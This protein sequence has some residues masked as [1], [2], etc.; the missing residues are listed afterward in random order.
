MSVL[1]AL[2][3]ASCLVASGP[4]EGPVRAALLAAALICVQLRL[5]CNLL[6]GMVAVEH[7]RGGPTGPIWNEL[8]DRIA[9]PLFLVAAG[10][11]AAGAGVVWGAPVG[12]LAGLLAVLTAYVRELGRA[13]GCPAD[14]SGPMAKPHRMAVLTAACAISIAEPLWRWRGQSLAIAL[15]I[16]ALGSALTVVLRTLRLARRLRERAS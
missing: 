3:G 8:P 2:I 4:A 10:Y 12:W 15:A 9:D 5:V 6:D 13:L 1:A 7:G 14:F 11:G 16:I